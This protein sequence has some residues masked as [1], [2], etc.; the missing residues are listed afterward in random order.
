MAIKIERVTV[1]GHRGVKDPTVGDNFI[2]QA[3]CLLEKFKRENPD[4]SS[5]EATTEDGSKLTI[6]VLRK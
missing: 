2:A 1:K 5:Y 3:A 4:L 6:R